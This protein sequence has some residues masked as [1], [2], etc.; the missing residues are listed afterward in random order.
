[1][2][3]Y[4]YILYMGLV[5]DEDNKLTRTHHVDYREPEHNLNKQWRITNTTTSTTMIIDNL[6]HITCV[7]AFGLS[8]IKRTKLR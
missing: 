3:I 7:F 6:K 4:I 2:Y 8:P 5:V 1:M